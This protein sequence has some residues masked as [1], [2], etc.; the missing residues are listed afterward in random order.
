[1]NFGNVNFNSITN[2]QIYGFIGATGVLTVLNAI[3]NHY[4]R[5]KSRKKRLPEKNLDT[6]TE[7][8]K[9]IDPVDPVEEYLTEE[10][11]EKM[12]EKIKN[13]VIH[14]TC[15]CIDKMNNSRVENKKEEKINESKPEKKPENEDEII[16]SEEKVKMPVS[17][18]LESK[19]EMDELIATIESKEEFIPKFEK[20]LFVH[21]PVVSGVQQMTCIFYLNKKKHIMFLI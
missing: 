3:K 8:S 2:K 21:R 15:I 20:D 16:I 5:L 10:I 13:G 14:T 18:G 19:I 9:I 12:V 17:E 11:V 7:I 1:M 6:S 4:L